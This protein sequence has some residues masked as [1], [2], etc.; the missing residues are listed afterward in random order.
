[1]SVLD[2]LWFPRAKPFF[3]WVVAHQR[4]ANALGRTNWERGNIEP[5]R[6]EYIDP[7]MIG[8]RALAVKHVDAAAAAEVMLRALR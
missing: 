8:C 3:A 1:M 5:V 2:L 4:H 7:T 6:A